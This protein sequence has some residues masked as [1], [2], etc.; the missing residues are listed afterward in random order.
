MTSIESKLHLPNY[1][2]VVSLPSVESK[3]HLPTYTSEVE[4][5]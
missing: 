2:S 3:L 5:G 1:I 4:L